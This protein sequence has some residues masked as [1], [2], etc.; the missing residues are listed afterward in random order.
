MR[1]QLPPRT[2]RERKRFLLWII[3]ESL[4]YGTRVASAIRKLGE[5]FS[6][7]ASIILRSLIELWINLQWIQIRDTEE[8]AKRFLTYE[9]VDAVKHMERIPA[10]I[11]GPWYDRILRERKRGYY[12]RV[13]AF[14]KPQKY[15]LGK[16]ET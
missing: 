8:R 14:Q 10:Q 6:F 13:K 9:A 15:V 2:M 5:D 12:N 7:E 11:R 16:E 3:W 1:P 4:L